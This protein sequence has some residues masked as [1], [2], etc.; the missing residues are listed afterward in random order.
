M[1]DLLGNFCNSHFKDV[2]EHHISVPKLQELL[3]RQQ[4]I[5]VLVEFRINRLHPPLHLPI[6]IGQRLACGAQAHQRFED[7]PH[8]V[9]LDEPIAI[10][11]AER[12]HPVQLLLSRTGFQTS[13]ND[14]QLLE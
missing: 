8:L 9:L 14:H 1:F 13:E 7:H 6:H 10:D 2:H 4:P 11:I 12:K 5:E 3:S